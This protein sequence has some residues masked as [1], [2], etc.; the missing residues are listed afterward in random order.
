VPAIRRAIFLRDSLGET[1]DMAY[2]GLFSSLSGALDEQGRH[3]EA[4]AT[5]RRALAILDSSGRGETMTRGI[6]QHD[7]ALSMMNLGEVAAAEPL[8]HD[9]LDRMSRSDPGADLPGQ[10]LIH[11]AHAA[12]FERHA[13]SAAK[14]FGILANQAAREHNN[15][16]EGR[17]R[18]GL[19]QAQLQLGDVAGARHTTARFDQLAAAQKRFSSDDQVTDPRMLHAMLALQSG[20]AATANSLVVQLLRSQGYFKGKRGMTSRSALILAA[21]T[22]LALHQPAEALD[23]ARGARATVTP[24]SLT[25]ARSA[26]IGEASLIEARALLASGDTSRA[27][28]TLAQAVTALRTGAGPTHPRTREAEALVTALQQ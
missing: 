18:F 27:R 24:D 19:A 2:V 10:P 8:F 15:Y 1:R 11:Y 13:D 21:E 7:Y 16:W 28:A 25:A 12:L 26:Y 3:R 22:A 23:Y 4:L 14:Y 6:V 17:G 20:D 9:L 5:Y